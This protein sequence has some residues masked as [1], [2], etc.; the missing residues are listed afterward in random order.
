[1]KASFKILRERDWNKIILL[2]GTSELYELMS[3]NIKNQSDF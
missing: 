3:C 1:M 2:E